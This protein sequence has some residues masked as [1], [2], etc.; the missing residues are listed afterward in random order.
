MVSPGVEA[1]GAGGKGRISWA[2]ACSANSKVNDRL[3]AV[4]SLPRFR[5]TFDFL[6]CSPLQIASSLPIQVS[7]PHFDPVIVAAS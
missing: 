7:L 3:S 1:D 5:F 6:T 4:V 2:P